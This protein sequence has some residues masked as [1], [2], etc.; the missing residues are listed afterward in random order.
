MVGSSCEKKNSDVPIKDLLDWFWFRVDHAGEVPHMR[1]TIRG[2]LCARVYGLQTRGLQFCAFQRC[3]HYLVLPQ[4]KIRVLPTHTSIVRLKRDCV[5]H[6]DGAKYPAPIWASFW[7]GMGRLPA[8]TQCKSM[9]CKN[10][11]FHQSSGG[12]MLHMT[13]GWPQ[14]FF[15]PWLR[16]NLCHGPQK[17][18][19]VPTP[20]SSMWRQADLPAKHTQQVPKIISV[21]AGLHIQCTKWRA[22]RQKHRV[23]VGMEIAYL[24]WSACGSQ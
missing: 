22:S 9:H 23:Q 18:F 13:R 3:A 12:L 15:G 10:R 2:L 4:P 8:H 5:V 6:G 11:P 14:G 20:L 17:M 16:F 21:Q 19:S 1:S 7:I 24:G